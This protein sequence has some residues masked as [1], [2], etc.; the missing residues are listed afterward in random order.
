MKKIPSIT[1][2]IIDKKDTYSSNLFELLSNKK[3][4]IFGVPGAFTPTCSENHLP[5]FI[6]L[7][8]Q[9]KNKNIDDIYCLAVNDKFVME[10]WL[11]SY[12]DGRKIKGIADGNA[13]ISKALE[14][15]SDKTLNFMGLRCKRFAM[16]VHNSNI[17]K[18]FIE[19][20]GKFEIT[21]ANNILKYI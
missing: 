3:V 8:D 2:P 11:S 10:S 16:I 5:S 19:E 15:T 13:E 7:Y 6:K 4:V 1:V 9:I 17:I 12:S 14:L 21:S 20:T 18:I